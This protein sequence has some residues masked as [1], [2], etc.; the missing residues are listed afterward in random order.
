MYKITAALGA[1]NHF[2][3]TMRTSKKILI[4]KDRMEL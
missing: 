4:K 2:Q 1:Q 3:N